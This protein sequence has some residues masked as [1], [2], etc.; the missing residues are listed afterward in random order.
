MHCVV[1]TNPIPTTR[2]KDAVTCSP[3]CTKARKNW[4]R[5][6]VDMEECRYC[7]KPSTPESRVLFGSWSRAMRKG[8]TD[9]QF[10]AQVL[11]VT[12][13]VH[14]NERLKRKLAELE[15]AS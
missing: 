15:V 11:E 12:R 2:K 7:H 6:R 8:M 9:E 5:S 10:V 1:C 3:Q 14:D 4:G 13:L